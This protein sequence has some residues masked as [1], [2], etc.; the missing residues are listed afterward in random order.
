MYSTPFLHW[1]LK[2]RPWIY[3]PLI[4]SMFCLPFTSILL[5]SCD[6][7]IHWNASGSFI[8]DFV[9]SWI[10]LLILFVFLYRGG[11]ISL[12]VCFDFSKLLSDYSVWTLI[13]MIIQ[14]SL[15]S[16]ESKSVRVIIDR[17]FSLVFTKTYRLSLLFLI[18]LHFSFLT[19][20]L[21]MLQI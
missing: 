3:Q 21:W 20:F 17:L 16:L 9:V 4:S 18:I 14:T 19:N 7:L 13:S 8:I 6:I 5:K 10:S 11:F 15:R 2:Q 1:E 12:F